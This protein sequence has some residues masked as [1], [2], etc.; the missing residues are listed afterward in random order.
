M[1]LLIATTLILCTFLRGL[2]QVTPS[3]IFSD[4][5]VLQRGQDIPVWGRAATKT[6]VKVTIDGQSASAT[7]NEKGAW[8]TILKPMIAGGP[9]VMT[10]SSGK[11]TLVY[12]DVMVGEVWICSGQSN[13]EFQLRNALGYNFEQKNAPSQT[14]RQFRVTDKMSLQPETDIK[15]GNWV[16]ADTNTVGD[17]TAVGYFFAKQL[18]KQLNVTVGLIYSNWGGT[19]AEDW[20]SKEAML[21]S[22]ELGEAAKNIPDTWDGVKQRID[23]QLKDWAYN[24][25]QVTNYSAEQLAGEPAAFFGDWQKA[26]APASW[27][28]T[29]KLYSYRGE[30][31]MQHTVKLDSSYVARHSVL[32]LGQTDADLELYV[33]GKLIKKG[34][35]SG[36]FQ[37]DLPAGTW[38][39]GDNSV[40]INLQSRQKNPSWFG[41]GLTG[42]ANDL[43]VRFADTTINLA[44]NNWYVMPDLSKPYHFDFLPNNTAFSLYNAMISPLIPYAIAGV[45]WYQ[46]ESN[47]DKAFQYRTTFPL[48]ITDWRSKWNRDFPFLFVQ[49]SSFGG[50]QNSNIGSNWAELREAQTMTLQLPNTG[51]AVTTD[52]GDALNIHPR[53]KADV[54]LRLASKALTMV[55]HLQGF[56]ESPLYTSADFSAGYAIVNFKN[57]VNGLMAKDKYGYIKGFELAGADHKFYYAQAGIIDGGKVKVWCSQV[58]KPVAVRYAWTDAPIEANLYN[59]EGFPVGPFRSDSWKGTTEGK[60]FE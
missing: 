23:K 29:G 28:W 9:Y 37:L 16:K 41:M 54:G 26:S 52:I 49:L 57:A 33:N 25:K 51:M 13:M 45:I 2:A 43:Y 53:D 60:K 32:S 50:M 6:K 47:A 35:S 31:F 7:A 46:G 39:P 42:G 1:R 48:L 40:L 38:K 55:Y 58:P 8:K 11:E 59:M 27:E 36:N 14:I 34:A 21:N 19:L 22:P 20:I 12:H 30:G 15:E 44:D 4:H 24:K 56:A 10:I 3:G 18:S 5:M 17:F